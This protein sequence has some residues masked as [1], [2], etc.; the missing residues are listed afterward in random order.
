MLSV[1]LCS[2]RRSANDERRA[3]TNVPSVAQNPHSSSRLSRSTTRGSTSPASFSTLTD[4]ISSTL[5]QPQVSTATG[6][7]LTCASLTSLNALNVL[8]LEPTINTPSHP[9]LARLASSAVAKGTP[10]PKK[11]TA[12]LSGPCLHFS[13]GGTTKSTTNSPSSST[14]PSG[15]VRRFGVP[16]SKP[17]EGVAPSS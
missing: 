15:R 9:S 10:S 1:Y 4:A 8:T 17:P 5:V 3:S 7:P 14:S 6:T 2:R 13:H 12:G 16:E 11:T